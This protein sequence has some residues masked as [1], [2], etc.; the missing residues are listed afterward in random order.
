M[1]TELQFTDFKQ[2]VARQ[3]NI[4]TKQP[5]FSSKA[6]KDDLWSTYLESFPEGSD[7]IFKERTVHDCQCCKQF[8]RSIGNAV[9]FS[10]NDNVMLTAWDIDI[11]GPYQVVADAMAAMIRAKGVDSV[12]VSDTS[13]IGTDISH[14][15]N[16]NGWTDYSH[17][18][19]HI[20]AFNVTARAEFASTKGLSRSQFAVLYRSLDEIT[21]DAIDI[22][23]DLIEQ[24]SL[25]LGDTYKEKV[26]TLLHL[27]NSFDF[28]DNKEGFVWLQSIN[29][30]EGCGIRNT[31]I[32][33]LLVDI[34]NDMELEK[35][36]K[37]FEK[38]VAPENY[39]RPKAL[40][41]QRQINQAN[42]EIQKLGLEDSLLRRYA[43][44]D[45]MSINDILFADR[46]A[47]ETMGLLD[48]LK[49]TKGVSAPTL[50]K[51]EKISITDFINNILPKIDSI[52]L[53]LE[54][55]H[56]NSLM[57]VIAPQYAGA[58]GI[59]KWDNNFTWSYN[60]EVTDSIKERVKS[61]GGSVTGD[62]RC[63]L[64][65]SNAD[66]LDIHIM[67]PSGKHIYY[68]ARQSAITGGTLDV[69]M[70]AGS[71]TNKINPVENITWPD[72]DRME[73]GEYKLQVHNF[74]KR[75]TE[76]VGFAVEVEFDGVIHTF[77]HAIDI[78]S[79]TYID[80]VTF[81]YS[82][83]TGLRIMESIPS[84][85]A[86]KEIWGVYTN[87]FHKVNMVMAS[88]N[89]WGGQTGGNAHVFFIL[90]ECVNPNPARGFYN[91]FLRG[92]LYKHRKVF[93]LLGS[94][95]KAPFDPNQLSGLGFSTTNRNAVLCRVRGSFNRDLA[96]QF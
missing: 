43:H 26:R 30:G 1:T 75:S 50:G 4:L 31:V 28:T 66:D 32:G 63:S 7:P 53:Y 78:T 81:I 33:T 47:K 46:S 42:E 49:P 74:Q 22:V 40:V 85:A 9:A 23:M 67:E 8:I 91:E 2:A 6:T 59:T 88:P 87:Q 52:E 90:D 48:I 51:V 62:L 34:S 12:F 54:N 89:Q 16:E 69:D 19:Y 72:R 61:A 70:N 96:I 14:A 83:T 45:D 95:L 92:D 64:A 20:P 37:S 13:R 60:G 36:V 68:S 80:V 35:A 77:H 73:E 71:R 84:T 18:Y 65:W 82:H 76:N 5:L 17:F 15:E 56:S 93:E 11:G 94:K 79:G 29:L 21:T 25:Y 10:P 38:K 3:L 24:G 57:S 55:Q 41:T 44:T 39:K 58:P 86:T 27:K